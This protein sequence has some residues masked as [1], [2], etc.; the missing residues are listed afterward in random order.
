MPIQFN[1]V[2][3]PHHYECNVLQVHFD[4][5]VFAFFGRHRWLLKANDTLWHRGGDN[6]ISPNLEWG[7]FGEKLAKC[8]QL[9][10]DAI[11]N[12]SSRVEM[13]HLKMSPEIGTEI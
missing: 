7:A 6:G 1:A 10:I 12:D 5:N 11:Q 9:Q 4:I 13:N 2:Q 3:M 8:C